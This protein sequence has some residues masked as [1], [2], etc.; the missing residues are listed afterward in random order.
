[1]EFGFGR[2]GL[3]RRSAAAELLAMTEKLVARVSRSA[4]AEPYLFLR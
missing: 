1:M 4:A 2:E 3:L